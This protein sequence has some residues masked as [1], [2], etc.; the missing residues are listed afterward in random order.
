MKKLAI[1]TFKHIPVENILAREGDS[2]KWAKAYLELSMRLGN[3]T[4]K[5]YWHKRFLGEQTATHSGEFRWWIWERENWTVCVSGRGI[6]FDV[7]S[8]ISAAEA[9]RYFKEYLEAIDMGGI[10]AE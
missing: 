3:F 7:L 6:E 2:G 5:L 9:W 1:E 10:I 4:N 8:D